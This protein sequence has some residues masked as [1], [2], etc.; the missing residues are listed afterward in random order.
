MGREPLKKRLIE[1]QVE[2][3]NGHGWVLEAATELRERKVNKKMM[4]NIEDF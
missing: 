1:L 3:E 2:G 4:I